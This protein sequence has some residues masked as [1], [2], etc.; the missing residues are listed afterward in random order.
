MYALAEYSCTKFCFHKTI[1]DLWYHW[2]YQSLSLCENDI[3]K[4]RENDD[5]ANI[6]KLD[7]GH[8][9]TDANCIHQKQNSPKPIIHRLTLKEEPKV[10][11]EQVSYKHF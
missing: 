11:S 5:L 2:I 10:K 9:R 3:L 8:W 1:T 7:L 6:L 4:M